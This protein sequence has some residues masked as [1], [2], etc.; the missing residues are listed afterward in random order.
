VQRKVFRIEAMRRPQ[1][2][3][4]PRNSLTDIQGALTTLLHD[5]KDKR[6]TRAAGDLGAAVEA[7]EKATDKILQAAEAIEACART[8]AAREAG[9]ARDIQD[10]L[11]RIYE[12]C[13]FQD[14]AGQ[15]I[16]KAIATLGLVE[17]GMAS[18]VARTTGL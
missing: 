15:R 18:L 9:L 11:L 8:L 1:A 3:P 2:A 16:G 12:A 10:Q 5:G 17:D 14:L 13:T 6:M 4:A 7:T